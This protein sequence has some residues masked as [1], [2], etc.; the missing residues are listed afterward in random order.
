M[1]SIFSLF[2]KD[3]MKIFLKDGKNLP[4]GWKLSVTSS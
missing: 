3:G 2:L 4:E 1:E